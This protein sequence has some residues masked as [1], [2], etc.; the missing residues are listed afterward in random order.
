M[1]FLYVDT[2]ALVKLYI[3]EPGSRRVSEVAGRAELVVTASVTY[4]EARAAIAARARLGH[5]TSEDE[6]QAVDWLDDDWAHLAVVQVTED[7]V[8]AAGDLAQVHALRGYDAVQLAACLVAQRALPGLRMAVY[9]DD[10]ARAA[11]LAGIRIA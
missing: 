1:S 2:S 10:L 11:E 3:D 6:I 4:V 8:H 7:L 5:L 9:D